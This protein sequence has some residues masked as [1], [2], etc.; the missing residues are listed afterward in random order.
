MATEQP[1]PSKPSTEA[2]A[3]KAVQ[4]VAVKVNTKARQLRD[5]IRQSGTLDK[6]VIK[7]LT[8]D[9]NIGI[10]IANLPRY[11][12]SNIARV[13]AEIDAKAEVEATIEPEVEVEAPVEVE[14]TVEVKAEA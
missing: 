7:Q 12:K 9:S 14:L 1:T 10:P 8:I 3:T 6:A 4:S 5:L 2:T 11:L 13:Q